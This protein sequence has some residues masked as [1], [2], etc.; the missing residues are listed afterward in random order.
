MTI[1]APAAD[2]TTAAPQASDTTTIGTRTI[3][4]DTFGRPD[5][6]PTPLRPYHHGLTPFRDP[7]RLP[8]VIRANRRRDVDEVTVRARVAE[9][10]LH[11]QLPRVTMWAYE[12]SVPGPTIEVERDRP[13]RI[14]WTNGMAGTI[15]VT[16]VNVDA[17]AEG[18]DAVAFIGTEQRKPGYPKGDE[19]QEPD[20]RMSA[21]PAWQVVHL[22]GALTD[23]W[24]DGWADNATASGG[25]T[26]SI[27]PNRQKSATLWYHDHPMDITRFNVYAG[28]SGFYL[29]RDN[30]ER[31]LDLPRGR[32]ELP[33]LLRDLNLDRD[34]DGRLAGRL[35][36][37]TGT[38]PH[39]LGAVDEHGKPLAG[40]ELPFNGPFDTVN[41]VIWPHHE[42]DARWH[43]LRLLN[44][45]N[46]RTYT[47]N[48]VDEDG[49][50]VNEH[51]R[52][53]GTDGGLLGAP[54][55]LPEG[56]I[57]ILPSERLDVLVD[58]GALRG[59][60]VRLVNGTGIVD[61]ATNREPALMEF[62][63]SRRATRDPFRLPTRLA[64]SFE[65]LTHASI[66]P[67]DHHFVALV[68]GNVAHA[69]DP[70]TGELVAQLGPEIW[71]LMPVEGHTG[72]LEPG[73]IEIENPS[74]GALTVYERVASRF[75]DGTFIHVDEGRWVQWN[76]I[77]LG[78]PTHP[79]HIHM[80]EFQ[81]LNRHRI[82][83]VL[84]A[85]PADVREPQQIASP[86]RVIREP[87]VPQTGEI[88]DGQNMVPWE[89]G[90]KDT[91]RVPAQQWVQVVGKFEGATGDFM[92]HCHLLDHEDHG[93]MRPFFV[94]PAGVGAFSHGSGHG[95]H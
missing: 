92:Y 84:Q 64:R 13:V 80:T 91:F 33:L 29:I 41:G 90:W 20:E 93:M 28:L 9:I 57:P 15:P 71:E 40:A 46:T 34:D 4:P 72:P 60:R 53:I 30:E 39:P 26:T 67:H 63:V 18:A 47:L 95:G 66:G 16:A 70:R 83:P 32:H 76:F 89:S 78:G 54:A 42:V 50:N 55:E 88:P 43:R 69:R 74:T 22:H 10:S 27:Y 38:L 24:N 35:L 5:H 81:I 21:L 6:A 31:S 49:E 79:M 59:R 11:S 51:V 62:R 61:D 14:H 8:P 86:V 2:A 68:P 94:R 58:F 25:V 75:H 56:G 3:E 48:L 77:N 7:L 23:G 36:Y 73:M 12:G 87:G 45:A 37:K 19:R 52:V 85:P 1:E 82:A 17:R 44:G 65:R